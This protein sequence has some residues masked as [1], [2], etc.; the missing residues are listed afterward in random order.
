MATKFSEI[1][2]LFLSQID[3]YDLIQVSEEEMDGV[4]EDYLRNCFVH[5]QH[6][7]IEVTDIDFEG[8]TFNTDLNY[9]EKTLVSKAMKLEWVG[10]KKHSG[11]LMRK[12]IGDRDYKAIQG[13]DYLKGLSDVEEK[14]RNEID[15]IMIDYSYS[16]DDFFGGWT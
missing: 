14:L 1:Y 12:S 9:I 16:K 5:L 6:M 8:K 4:I 2:S 3:D 13:V 7:M 15:R 11:E 10:G